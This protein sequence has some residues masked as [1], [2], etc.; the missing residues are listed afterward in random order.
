[1]K[2]IRILIAI[3]VSTLLI[4]GCGSDNDSNINIIKDK[5]FSGTW[6]F[7]GKLKKN[8]KYNKLPPLL[9]VEIHIEQDERYIKVM[10]DDKSLI[11]VG[12]LNE[13]DDGF[14]TL[15]SY[16]EGDCGIFNSLNITNVS[17][18]KGDASLTIKQ[19]CKEYSCI[20]MYNGSI[21][22]INN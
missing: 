6:Y 13:G 20:A 8:C 19:N 9:Y 5:S 15:G 21:Q 22:K 7:L 16:K 2:N 12:S 14:S 4:I 11:G 18:I 1:M 17:G 3:A 10:S